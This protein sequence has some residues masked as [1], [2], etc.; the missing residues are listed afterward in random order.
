M[1]GQ[2]FTQYF[3][4]DGIHTTAEWESVGAAFSEFRS[5]IA[6]LY[7]NFS[8]RANPNEAETEQDLIRPVLEL[9]GWSDY[10]PQQGTAQHEQVP[11]HLLFRDS[12]GKDQAAVRPNT[13][14]RYQYAMVVQESKRF[15][16]SLDSHDKNESNPHDQI[17]SYLETAAS[18]TDGE[19]RWGLLSNG[20]IWRL[21]DRLKRP[22]SDSYV[23]FDVG[24]CLT[25]I[26]KE[27][28]S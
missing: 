8:V 4:T 13:A 24:D 28:L 10:V 12:K 20:R 19:I 22:R 26:S 3:L 16:L 18:S 11:D 21:Y 15:G 5:A 25:K 23:E 6:P 2:L 9:L 1:S 17:L 7:D 14:D 27:Q